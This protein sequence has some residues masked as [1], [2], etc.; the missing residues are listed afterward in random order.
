MMKEIGQTM[1]RGKQRVL[2]DFS[3]TLEAAIAQQSFE[4]ITVNSLCKAAN[5]PRSTFYNYFD[6][7]YDLLRYC[8]SLVIAEVK[9]DELVVGH[10]DQFLVQ[11]FDRLYTL[12]DAHS[13]YV[14]R[15]LHH[16]QTGD[17]QVNFT[18]YARQKAQKELTG[19]LNVGTTIPT[20][21]VISHCVSTLLMVL[22]WTFVK[23]HKTDQ[24]T[25]RAIL[26]K[27]YGSGELR[28][29]LDKL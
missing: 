18:T 24:A 11:S 13:D 16:N 15:V 12:T 8:F 23:Q 17:L 21:L 27:L 20:E 14:K 3:K 2:N 26:L 10:D 19:K 28:Q 1:T 29:A 5:Y 22:E 7:K 6:D 9:L 25:A 4:S